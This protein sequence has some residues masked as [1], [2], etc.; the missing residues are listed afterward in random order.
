MSGLS[1]VSDALVRELRQ[2]A[3]CRGVSVEMLLRELL[4][5]PLE[6]PVRMPTFKGD[7][8][9]LLP[10][11]T[12][13]RGERKER[14]Y[15]AVVRDGQIEYQGVRYSPS[16]AAMV[17][18]RAIE[19]VNLNGWDFWRVWQ[20]GRWVR[21]QRFRSQPPKANYKARG[22]RPNYGRGKLDAEALA[23]LTRLYRDE[24]HSLSEVLLLMPTFTRAMLRNAIHLHNLTRKQAASSTTTHPVEA[25]R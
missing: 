10:D 14:T 18:V 12:P 3:A 8:R 21:L 11:G 5:L 23:T 13:V 6:L 19:A 15:E 7:L 1:E 17:A 20:G 22:V 2:R 16:Q 25:P 9:V 4:R 24:K